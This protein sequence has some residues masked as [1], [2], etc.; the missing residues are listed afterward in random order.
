M[1][2]PRDLYQW[3]LTQSPPPVDLAAIS[4]VCIR[5]SGL[6]VK[7]VFVAVYGSRPKIKNKK[8][9][10]VEGRKKYD[11]NDCVSKKKITLTIILL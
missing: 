4:Y 9:I 8:P 2:S 10:P 6:C 1:N 5:V 3:I 11:Y 7:D